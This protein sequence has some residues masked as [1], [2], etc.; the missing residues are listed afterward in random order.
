MDGFQHVYLQIGVMV[1]GEFLLLYSCTLPLN[2][3]V[4]SF[5]RIARRQC[6]EHMLRL[7]DL[8]SAKEAADHLDRVWRERRFLAL[9]QGVS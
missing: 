5:Y 2:R 7:S 6:K 1:A 3:S 8:H 9:M 4:L